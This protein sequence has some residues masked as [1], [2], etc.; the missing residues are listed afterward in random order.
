LYNI[1]Q[2]EKLKSSPALV[3]GISAEMGLG[4]FYIHPYF[5]IQYLLVLLDFIK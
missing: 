2:E 3:A 1:K 5:F 4:L